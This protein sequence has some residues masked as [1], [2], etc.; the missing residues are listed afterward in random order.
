MRASRRHPG[1]Q[2]LP[3]PGLAV[4]ELLRLLVAQ[5]YRHPGDRRYGDGSA[6]RFTGDLDQF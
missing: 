4:T 3:R 5:G 2:K 1:G 6:L